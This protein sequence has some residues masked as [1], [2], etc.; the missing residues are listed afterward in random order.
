MAREDEEDENSSPDIPSFDDLVDEVRERKVKKKDQTGANERSDTA[1]SSADTEKTGATDHDGDW[2]WGGAESVD[3]TGDT[4]SGSSVDALWGESGTSQSSESIDQFDA[5]KAEALIE[6]ID[7]APNVLLVGPAGIPVEHDICT[8]LCDVERDGER[9][10]LLITTEQTAE[11]RLES[12]RP[13][14]NEPY[15]DTTIIV[16]GNQARS[17]NRTE[18]T[19]QQIGGET[20]KI[21][22]LHDPN[23]LTRLGVLI[24]KYLGS[25]ES[26]PVICFHTLNSLLQFVGIEK[27]FR[28]LHILQARVRSVDGQA[29]YQIDP[30]HLEMEAV[31][32]LQPLFDFTVKYAED[33][34]ISVDSR[35]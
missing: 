32:T 16:V 24:N 10:R 25:G 18:P 22:T 5:S 30:G 27:L 33:G 34:A 31:Q 17:N 35:T 15:D 11:E 8:K 6:I 3:K 23:D 4:D 26:S 21:E 14:T 9:R 29:H 28:F 12:L 20:V 2:E 19:T 7:D 13:Y 1:T